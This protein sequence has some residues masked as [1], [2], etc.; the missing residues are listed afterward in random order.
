MGRFS[1]AHTT[2]RD[3]LPGPPPCGRRTPTLYCDMA[4]PRPGSAVLARYGAIFEN[5]AEEE[6]KKVESI[7]ELCRKSRGWR[8]WRGSPRHFTKVATLS[9]LIADQGIGNTFYLSS[10]QWVAD[11]FT[12]LGL[13]GFPRDC[14]GASG[15]Q[16]LRS[17]VNQGLACSSILRDPRN[18]QCPQP[19]RRIC[20]P[21]GEPSVG[22]RLGP[23]LGV[24]GWESLGGSPRLGLLWDLGCGT[25]A[26]SAQLGLGGGHWLDTDLVAL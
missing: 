21:P 10:L 24:L 26:R 14:Q 3:D 19:P 9:F 4:S 25:S 17:L 7:V 16:I 23:R 1:G 20:A 15:F 8:R 18:L 6:N 12:V 5:L 22:F 11:T 2:R 13:I